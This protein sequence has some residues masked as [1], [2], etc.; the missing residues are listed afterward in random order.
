[1]FAILV[2][3]ILEYSIWNVIFKNVVNRLVKLHFDL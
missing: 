2:S 1:M 3:T